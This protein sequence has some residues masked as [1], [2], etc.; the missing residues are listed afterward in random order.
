[1]S[2]CTLTPELSWE[3]RRAARIRVE[4]RPRRR[5]FTRYCDHCGHRWRRLGCPEHMW[6]VDILSY[7]SDILVPARSKPRKP[8]PRGGRHGRSYRGAIASAAANARH[9]YEHTGCI[10]SPSYGPWA[11]TAGLTVVRRWTF[12]PRACPHAPI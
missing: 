4:H 3:L 7:T 2:W 6:A 12:R 11:L 8:K 5:L 1:M 10:K 9:A